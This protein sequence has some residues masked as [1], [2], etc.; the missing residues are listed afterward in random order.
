MRLPLKKDRETAFHLIKT[1][2]ERIAD[3]D[4]M[5]KKPFS[6]FTNEEEAEDFLIVGIG[7]SAGGIQALKE[8]FQQVPADSGL[9]YVVILHLS[10]DHDSRLAEVLQVVA[11][12]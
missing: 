5:K 6:G 4:F 12:M 9:A 8:F 10:P 11:A 1:I 3:Q 7:A 2:P